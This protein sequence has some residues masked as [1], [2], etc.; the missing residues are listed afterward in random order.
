[1]TDDISN[2]LRQF[3]VGLNNARVGRQE[4]LREI[5]YF[6]TWGCYPSKAGEFDGK[7]KAAN[8]L[9][10]SS[11]DQC[12]VCSAI[13]VSLAQRDAQVIGCYNPLPTRKVVGDSHTVALG[14]LEDE[15]KLVF[16]SSLCQHSRQGKLYRNPAQCSVVR[17]GCSKAFSIWCLF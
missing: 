2:C 9:G 5:V 16:L 13:H 7:N 10:A 15:T 6:W 4:R 14:T 11:Y 1:M 3:K 17:S 8:S 12:P